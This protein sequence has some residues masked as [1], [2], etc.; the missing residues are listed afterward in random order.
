[1][2]F[3]LILFLLF[4][5]FQSIAQTLTDSNLP[6]VIISIDGN[7]EIPSDPR[8]NGNMKI[9]YRGEG[10][11]NFVS[12][13]NTE[14]FLDYDGRIEIEIRGS[15]SELLEKKQF[16][17]ST[18]E[19]DDSDTD[20]VRLL[21]MPSENDWIFNGLAY[22]ASLIR[23][24]ISY[25]LAR[26]M[27]EYAPRT[28]FCEVIINDDYKGLYILQ[29]RIKADGDR[30]DINRIDEL[31]NSQPNL[32]GGYITKTDKVDDSDPSAWF[33]P[34]R[35]SNGNDFVHVVPDPDDVTSAQHEYIKSVFDDLLATAGANNESITNG[36]PS[37][38]DMPSFIHFM[39][40]SELSSNVDSY[41]F[42][43]YYHKDR[44]G[45]LR[46]GP[47]WDYNLTFGN[48]L[49]FWELDRSHTDVWQFDNG[50]NIGPD[51]WYDLFNNSLF[52]CYLSKRWFELTAS[53][54][55]LNLTSLE[56]Y[57]DEIV[58]YI[59]EA[60]AR[61][62]Q[63]WGT[64]GD[65]AQEI[66]DMKSWLGSRVDWMNNNIGSSESCDNVVTPPLVITKINYRPESHP[67]AGSSNQ[68]FIEILNNGSETID[69]TGV[70]IGGTG[71]VYQFPTDS[72]LGAGE[73]LVL[74]NNVATYNQKY[75][76]DPF[77]E[78]RRSLSNDGQTIS[79]LDAYGN[80]IDEVTY[81]DQLPWPVEADGDGYYLELIDPDLD[82][83]DP[84][85]WQAT[86][87]ATLTLSV[88]EESTSEIQ[89]YP[90]P[91]NDL[92]Y[93]KSQDVIYTAQLV[94]LNGK[95]LLTKGI[96]SKDYQLRLEGIDQGV[97][98]LQLVSKEGK[99]VYRIVKL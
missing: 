20:N 86:S 4:V 67:V 29:E 55:P 93:I 64:V 3:S 58:A 54:Q 94:D 7:Q 39:L 68:E 61:E 27:G 11:R 1:M 74:A 85:N 63:R 97:Y 98:F 88:L 52:N 83:N 6:I 32:S 26:Q 53:G 96:Y 66:S 35:Y 33:Y 48:D 31:D 41:T 51:Y 47:I 57:I 44:G 2:R 84:L 36:F 59:S 70:Y 24:Y 10:E 77:D 30:V 12:D 78:Y 37:I 43:T 82:N 13:Q 5:A 71:L 40:I 91:S 18:L 81:N 89:V 15:S 79:L 60:A 28:Q 17:F 72:E 65:H 90:V 9:I 42:S 69:L 19:P 23:D 21:G 8:V 76:E 34:A 49:D 75:G 95:T 62:N 92:V 38:I 80:V 25:N 50:D 73:A 16:G 14:E 87:D 46:A 56:N 22:D 45:K 99:S